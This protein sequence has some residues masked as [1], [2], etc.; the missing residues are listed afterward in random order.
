MFCGASDQVGR[1]GHVTDWPA[2][3][4]EGSLLLPT[5]DPFLTLVI[6]FTHHWLQAIL[7][8]RL[9]N[10]SSIQGDGISFSVLIENEAQ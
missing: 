8:P 3:F 7:L 2:D 9:V 6:D 5:P 4:C 10:G 1:Q